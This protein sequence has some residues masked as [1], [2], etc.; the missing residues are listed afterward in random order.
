MKKILILVLLLTLSLSVYSQIDDSFVASSAPI[1]ELPSEQTYQNIESRA[2]NLRAKPPVEE[3]DGG[4]Q[5]VPVGNSD[6]M[7]V[8]A[9]AIAFLY[10]R[11]LREKKMSKGHRF[12]Y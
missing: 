3:G 9:F 5:K 1:A 4:A 7:Q 10:L 8:S 12:F 6:I 11:K 2:P